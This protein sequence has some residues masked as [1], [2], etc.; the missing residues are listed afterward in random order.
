MI[1]LTHAFKA[2]RPCHILTYI[3]HRTALAK[4]T[5]IQN[6]RCGQ[7]CTSFRAL[8]VDPPSKEEA[9]LV[10][11]RTLVSLLF[12][13]QSGDLVEQL[14]GQGATVMAMDCIP[15]TLSRGQTYDALSSQVG[16]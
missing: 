15:R 14:E 12:P 5:R 2:F 7:L 1:L 10:E 9:A 13:A 16:A 8:Q 11:S 4:S 6:R 3:S